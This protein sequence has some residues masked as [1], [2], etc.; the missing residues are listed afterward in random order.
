MADSLVVPARF[1]GPAGSGNGGYVSGLLAG[2]LPGNRLFEGATVS[3]RTPP[4][5]DT[6][7]TVSGTDEGVELYNGVLLVGH[8]VAAEVD[9]PAGEGV[10]YAEAKDAEATF[11]TQ[12]GNPYPTCFVCGPEHPDGMRLFPGPV[13]EGVT[14]CTWTPEAPS[15]EL[16]WAALDCPGGWTV[17]GTGRPFLLARY[18]VR[19]TRTPEAGEPC[20][21]TGRLLKLDGRKA[22]TATALLGAD[23]ETIAHG[24]ALWIAPRIP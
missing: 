1:N 13:G 12:A 23:G 9:A 5:L 19:V 2:R 6:P 16:V 11:L 22:F 4:P 10:S 3:L 21:V 8:A 24:D 20:V 15:A 7:M 14:A 18:S 17:M